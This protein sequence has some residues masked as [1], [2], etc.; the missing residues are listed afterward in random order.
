M[1]AV[2]GAGGATGLE[3]VRKL[4]AQGTPVRAVVRNVEKYSGCFPKNTEIMAGDVTDEESLKTAF[5]NCE[6]VIFAASA[7][8]YWSGPKEIDFLGVQKT[9]NAANSVGVKRVVL[10][11]SRYNFLQ[12]HALNGNTCLFVGL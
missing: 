9:A 7:S 3:C 10:I 5:S 4:A 6:A 8:S 1:I 11:S 12:S 2:I